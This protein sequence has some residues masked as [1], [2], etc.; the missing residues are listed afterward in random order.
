MGFD[1]RW[2]AKAWM[3]KILFNEWLER[4][5]THVRLRGRTVVLLLDNCSAHG[6]DHEVA[7]LNL[8]NTRVIFLPP[9]TTSL[10]QPCDA[11]IIAA[12]KCRYRRLQIA[13]V[14]DYID[15]G[16]RNIYKVDVLQAMRWIQKCWNE[17]PAEAIYNCWRHTKLVDGDI[18]SVAV[19][20]VENELTSLRDDISDVVRTVDRRMLVETLLNNPSENSATAEVTDDEIIGFV[21]NGMTDTGE[22]EDIEGQTPPSLPSRREQLRILAT[23]R[24]IMEQYGGYAHTTGGISRVQREIRRDQQDSAI[25]TKITSFWG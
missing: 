23:A 3:T 13:R 6:K 22:N 2:N 19:E 14:L 20:G 15:I 21:L 11:G 1:Y 9:N 17:L 7:A 4:F 8:S 12:V 18:D 24:L 16:E 25:Q 5:N 10:I